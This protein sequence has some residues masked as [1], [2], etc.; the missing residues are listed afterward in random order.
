MRTHRHEWTAGARI[1]A[2]GTLVAAT[3]AFGPAGAVDGDAVR[4]A[5]PGVIDGE[6]MHLELERSEPAA[7]AAVHESPTEIRLWFTQTP[8]IEGTS[9]RVLPVGGEPLETGDARLAE[10][11]DTLVVA[12]LGAPLANGR[13]EVRWRA[14]ARDGHVVRGTFEFQVDIAR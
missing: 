12:T 10:D 6:A 3:A 14:L 1:A 4:P 11:D 8:E 5:A 13:Y 2:L 9:V 7:D